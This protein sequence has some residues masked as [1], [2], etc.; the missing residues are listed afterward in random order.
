MMSSSYCA[1][2]LHFPDNY[3]VDYSCIYLLIICVRC[4]K[5]YFS[6]SFIRVYV[7]AHMC[8]GMDAHVD[9]YMWRKEVS[10]RCH[11]SVSHPA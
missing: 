11:Y 4:F 5:K 3:D 1:L 6:G 10:L 9:I 2:D 8:E 7:G